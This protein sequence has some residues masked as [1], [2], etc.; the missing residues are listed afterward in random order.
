MSEQ[1]SL[2]EA[3]DEDRIVYLIEKAMPDYLKKSGKVYIKP[4]SENTPYVSI[5]FSPINGTSCYRTKEIPDGLICRVKSTGKMKYVS[6]SSQFEKNLT[7]NGLNITKIQSED[8]WRVEL[9]DFYSFA[10]ADSDAFSRLIAA[11][12]VSLFAFDRFDCC[13]K[14]RECSDAGKCLHDDMIYS[15]ACTYRKKLESGI[16]FYGK[17]RTLTPPKSTTVDPIKQGTKKIIKDRETACKP[18]RPNPTI[19]ATIQ[20]TD[21]WK[22]FESKQEKLQKYKEWK[23]LSD[24][25]T[26]I[27]ALIYSG[28]YTDIPTIC[29]IVG[30]TSHNEVVIQLGYQLHTIN[31]I[32]LL[33]MQ[34]FDTPA[35]LPSKT[36]PTEYIVLDLETTGFGAD[37]QKVV[38]IAAVKV[39]NGEITGRF[40]TLVNPEM[41]ISSRITKINHI[42]DEDVKDAPTIQSVITGFI[43]FI[44]DFPLVAHNGNTFDFK[45]IKKEADAI[46]R[47]VT[48]PT[49]DTLTLARLAFPE[50]QNYQLS[51]LVEYLGIETKNTHRAMPD[52]LAT[53]S[54]FQK[55]Y[56]EFIPKT[57]LIIS[58]E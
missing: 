44:E 5:M 32:Y 35:K 11:V 33:Q 46:G 36:I 52:V 18:A 3:S 29:D 27:K 26:Y 13:G 25:A 21:D 9:N 31:P 20:P 34:T 55:C 14:F 10:S 49:F 51:T 38:E 1:T 47:K 42:S 48:N 16:V 53:V 23:F 7:E 2:F 24:K 45:F 28:F 6:F 41:H 57:K 8:F 15:T 22:R 17:N 12:I 50:A 58:E 40:E 39:Q 56:E 19:K 4:N 30:Y 37:E 43:D 54:L